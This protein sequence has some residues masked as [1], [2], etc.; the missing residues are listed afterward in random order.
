[1]RKA[2]LAVYSQLVHRGS[3]RGP[4]RWRKSLPLLL[5]S[6]VVHDGQCHIHRT[7]DSK[8]ANRSPT[9]LLCSADV[10]PPAAPRTPSGRQC[11]RPIRARA[12]RSGA[13]LRWPGACTATL[14]GAV[15]VGSN[16]TGGT[17]Q[18]HKFEH[19]DNLGLTQPQACDLRQRRD[20]PD[21]APESP[22]EAEPS[23]GKPQ[24]TGQPCGRPPGRCP[25]QRPLL[26]GQYPQLDS[27]RQCGADDA[28]GG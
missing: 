22:P 7:Y 18:R 15:S 16:P 14:S 17:G 21:L 25:D 3:H 26:F 9:S 23:R 6:R 8:P 5:V 10:S 19:S 20:V 12:S 27:S 2:E 13:R 24:L 28:G 4:L 1:M 11:L